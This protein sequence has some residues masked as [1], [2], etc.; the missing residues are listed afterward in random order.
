MRGLVLL[1]K[2]GPIFVFFLHKWQLEN[3]YSITT[4]QS[5]MVTFVSVNFLISGRFEFELKDN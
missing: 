5:S 3:K 1:A 2:G 4:F